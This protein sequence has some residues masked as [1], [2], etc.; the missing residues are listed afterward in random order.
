MEFPSFNIGSLRRYL[1]WIFN[2]I[3]PANDETKRLTQGGVM[4]K[5]LAKGDLVEWGLG[6]EVKLEDGEVKVAAKISLLKLVDKAAE[7][8]P[9]EGGVEALVVEIAKQAIKAI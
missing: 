4:A 9:G 2:S 5:E 3:K 7:A 1:G 6:Y 8:V